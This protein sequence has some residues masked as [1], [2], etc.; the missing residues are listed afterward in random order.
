MLPADS[1]VDPDAE[2]QSVPSDPWASHLVRARPSRP[3]GD[4][5]LP[6]HGGLAWVPLTR[7]RQAVEEEDSMAAAAAAAAAGEQ[8]DAEDMDDY[9]ERTRAERAWARARGE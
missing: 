4:D 5:R 2:S 9:L 1:D 8:C 7:A 6:G 3:H